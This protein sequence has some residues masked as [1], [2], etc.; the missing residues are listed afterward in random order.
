MS[1]GVLEAFKDELYYNPPQAVISIARISNIATAL[2]AER[3]CKELL[4]YFTSEIQ[5]GNLGD[6]VLRSI[7]ESLHQLVPFITTIEDAGYLVAPLRELCCLEEHSVRDHAVKT[8]R[9]IGAKLP[10]SLLAPLMVPMVLDLGTQDD[11]FTPRVSACGLMALA[12]GF[13]AS[14]DGCAAATAA[15][16][17][18]AA[19]TAADVAD[20]ESTSAGSSFRSTCG[21]AAVSHVSPPNGRPADASSSATSDVSPVAIPGT[22]ASSSSTPL[23]ASPLASLSS[24][25]A[26]SFSGLASPF[27]PKPS[28][29][30]PPSPMRELEGGRGGGPGASAS[31]WSSGIRSGA[32]SA[33]CAAAADAPPVTSSSSSGA[34]PAWQAAG[35]RGLGAAAVGAATARSGGSTMRGAAAELVSLYTALCADEHMAV[36]GSAAAA[37]VEV[38]AELQS[39]ERV[40]A[41]LESSFVTLLSDE[42]PAVRT[43]ALGAAADMMEA[44]THDV[45]GA[46]AAS[47]PVAAALSGVTR[48]K[49]AAVRVALAEALPAIARASGAGSWLAREIAISLVA[50]VDMD[51]RLAVVLQSCALCDGLGSPFVGTSLLPTLDVLIR[52]ESV[53]GRADLASVLMQL[54]RSL[55]P[56]KATEKLLPLVHLLIDDANVNVRLSVINRFCDLVAVVGM[57][58]GFGG[59][60]GGGGGGGAAADTVGGGLG[61]AG[62]GGGAGRG[63]E[64][65]AGESAGGEG[66]NEGGHEGGHEGGGGGNEG[67]GGSGGG[68]GGSG[69]NGG[70]GGSGGNGGGRSS[71]AFVDVLR[72]LGQDANWRV[73]H[74]ALM[75]LP[76]IASLMP[77]AE[78]SAAFDLD[79]FA[80]DRCALVR[81][82]LLNV[83]AT[84]AELPGYGAQWAEAAVLPV[85]RS[86]HAE[87]RSYE[88]RAVLLEGL[89]TLAKHMRTKALEEELL[90][91]ALSMSTDGVPNLRL[92]LT[93]ALA[94]AAPYLSGRTLAREV[95]PALQALEKDED[96]DVLGGAREALEVCLPLAQTL[97][98]S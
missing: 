26:S 30:P 43:A 81:L 50:D 66:G 79:A 24:S 53:G 76:A 70:N 98:Q 64:G 4:P 59:G 19:A 55:G 67:G 41:L 1:Q 6:D 48:D 87:V 38:A 21:P 77:P 44:V 58:A 96:M 32:G 11:W 47:H 89:A 16:A 65:E 31:G 73:R 57:D 13:S 94:R 92:L 62:V 71:S 56:R 88:R 27:L 23:S 12:I 74:A 29:T 28:A 7:A 51:V 90:P 37:M 34:V 93:D 95:V 42:A 83:C 91:L 18:A 15:A 40:A 36:R 22:E 60:G 52:D 61:G 20:G 45:S 80:I 72:A 85:L 2:G 9:R 68:N 35:L 10:A 39:H 84:V 75:Q 78:F 69:G 3:T 86:R 46:L 54:G 25:L 14:A 33:V 82:D 97:G 63:G 49:T 17:T 8:L 5:Q